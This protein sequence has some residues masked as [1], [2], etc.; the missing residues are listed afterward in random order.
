MSS[1][2]RSTV[3]TWSNMKTWSNMWTVDSEPA[4]DHSLLLTVECIKPCWGSAPVFENTFKFCC[5]FF[6]L[7]CFFFGDIQSELLLVR[8]DVHGPSTRLFW[9]VFALCSVAVTDTVGSVFVMQLQSVRRMRSSAAKPPQFGLHR[10][11]R[12]KIPITWGTAVCCEI[13]VGFDPDQSLPTESFL[14]WESTTSGEHGNSHM[15]K[16][17]SDRT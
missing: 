3:L 11:N 13:T 15:F 8:V 9:P 14:L 1:G 2:Q 12:N 4:V 17:S 10:R 16:S 5:C 6:F 7:L